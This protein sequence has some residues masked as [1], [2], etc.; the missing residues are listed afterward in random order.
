[1]GM[2]DERIPS[3]SLFEASMS[4]YVPQ[5]KVT[6]SDIQA[7]RKACADEADLPVKVSE[8]I[9]VDYSPLESIPDISLQFIV[10]GGPFM[11][12]DYRIVGGPDDGKRVTLVPWRSRESVSDVAS[13]Y[14]GTAEEAEATYGYSA[15]PALHYY[16]SLHISTIMFIRGMLR[17]DREHLMVH[18]LNEMQDIYYRRRAAGLED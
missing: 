3:T 16:S 14:N 7:F 17:E 8:H 12:F 13:K 11:T 10:G 2:W 5:P 18:E 4:T 9:T 6:F 15:R 1:M